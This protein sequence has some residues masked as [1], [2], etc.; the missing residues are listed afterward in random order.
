M[1]ETEMQIRPVQPA[2]REP[3]RRALEPVNTTAHARNVHWFFAPGATLFQRLRFRFKATLISLIFLLPVLLLGWLFVTSS[4]ERVDSTNLERQGLAYVREIL[5]AIQYARQFRHYTLADAVSGATSPE[6]ADLREKLKHQFDIIHRSDERVGEQFH[7]HKVLLR[8]E[9]FQKECASAADGVFKVYASHAKFNAAMTELLNDV[10]DGSGLTLDPDLDTYYLMDAGMLSTPTVLE[11]SAKMRGLAAAVA[12]TGKNAELAMQELA[13]QD[14]IIDL[15]AGTL[16]SD[17]KKVVGAHPE[18]QA[19]LEANV[20]LGELNKLRDLAGDALDTGGVAKANAIDAAGAAVV[21]RLESF[22]AIAVGHLDDLLAARVQKFNRSLVQAL[23]IVLL[24]LALAAYLFGAFTLSIGNVLYDI[25]K[26]FGRM[27]EGNLT[28]ELGVDG[29]DEMT[30]LAR[31]L[32]LMRHS[33]CKIVSLVRDN[34]DQIASSSDEVANGAEDLATRTDQAALSVQDSAASI[35][36]ISSTVKVT[37]DTAQQAARL[38]DQNTEHARRGGLVMTQMEQTMESIRGASTKIG[39]I[40]GVIDGIAFQTNILAL[41]AAVEAARA[42]EAG[43]GFAVVATEVRSLAQRSAEAAREIK[44]L[45][46][47]SVGQVQEGVLTV[48]EAG[49]T[50][51]QIVESAQRIN[52]L[53]GEIHI[54]AGE[55]AAGITQI[56]QSLQELDQAT[57]ENSSLVDE[58]ATAAV[59]Q[60]QLTTALVQEMLYFTLPA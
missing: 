12:A 55:Q 45:I 27:A 29:S 44:R 41:N 10:T 23:G 6:L 5:P 1:N 4:S 58:T 49:R 47:A 35:M 33:L 37:A 51:L 2:I 39:D 54:S 50:I 43:R 31:S 40:I 8:A 36:Q 42:G 11:A 52:A 57:R 21:T 20:S 25:R 28:V 19:S 7:S 3:Q 18:F 46:A 26:Q 32:E 59:S 14:G 60:K 24:F 13:R 48:Q 53:L 16:A 34:A 38:S 17:L 56:E 9:Q 15:V 22:Q 30:E